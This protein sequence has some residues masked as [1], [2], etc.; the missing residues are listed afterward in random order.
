LW[1]SQKP[2]RWVVILGE[3]RIQGLDLKMRAIAAL[4]LVAQH[5]QEFLSRWEDIHG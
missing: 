5:Q 2:K 1:P 3:K 4:K